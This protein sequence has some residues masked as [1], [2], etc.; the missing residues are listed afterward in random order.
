MRSFVCDRRCDAAHVHG[1]AP[2]DALSFVPMAANSVLVPDANLVPEKPGAVLQL[3]KPLGRVASMPMLQSTPIPEPGK[4]GMGS[5]FVTDAHRT[6][7]TL[8]R[9]FSQR[10]LSDLLHRS[11]SASH[12]SQ[13]PHRRGDLPSSGLIRSQSST[14]ISPLV[15]VASLS[16]LPTH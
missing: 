7:A 14:G 2:A 1:D 5:S 10:S 11:S 16:Q 4:L 8:V 13:L 3:S 9:K 6:I 12:L 15:R